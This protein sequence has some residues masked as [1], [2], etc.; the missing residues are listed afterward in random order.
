LTGFKYGWE[1]RK[2]QVVNYP[3]QGSAFHCLLWSLIRVHKILKKRNYQTRIIGQIH[4]SIVL[5]VHPPEL[6][7]VSK[8]VKKTTTKAL[9]QEWDWITLPLKVDAELGRVDGSWASLEKYKLP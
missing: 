9:Q 7:A 3:V 1:M 6:E 5:D 8:L 2:N 4:D